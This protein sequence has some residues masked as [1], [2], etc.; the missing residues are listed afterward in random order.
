MEYRR[1]P[2]QFCDDAERIGLS[3]IKK[4]ADYSLAAE[5]WTPCS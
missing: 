1:E 2:S 5:P 3:S 4:A